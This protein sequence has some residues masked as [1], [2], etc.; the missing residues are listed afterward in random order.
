MPDKGG[1]EVL[2]EIKAIDP[3]LPVLVLSGH[4]EDES[5]ERFLKFGAS[6]YVT[7]AGAPTELVAAIRKVL[8]GGR[9]VSAALAEKIVGHIGIDTGKLP[10]ER[11]SNREFQILRLIASGKPVGKIAIELGLSP[12]TIS[13][14]RT[15]MLQKMGLANSAEL[16]H[17]AITNNLVEPM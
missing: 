15:R 10:H 9:Y 4:P 1:F 3:K 13:T 2:R 17:Y 5:A 12:K 11:L 8:S 14:Y 16:M 7:K 6:G